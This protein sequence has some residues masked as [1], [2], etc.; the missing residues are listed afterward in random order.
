MMALL[1]NLAT[2]SL[3]LPTLTVPFARPAAATSLRDALVAS[4]T[5]GAVADPVEV[6][7]LIAELAA[8][9]VPFRA[10]CLGDTA[11]PS[12]I[13][14]ACYSSGRTPRWERNAKLLSGFVQNRAGQAY[15]AKSQRVCNYGEVLGPSVYFTAE[16]SYSAVDSSRRCPK[17]FNVR[18]E[19][20]GFVLLGKPFVSG[21]ISGPGYLRVLY[22]D[23][24]VRIFESPTDSPDKWEEAGLR[25]VQVNERNF[26]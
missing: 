8:A 9:R 19:Q 11:D 16:G 18:I 6:D 25:V 2:P 20:G 7:A 13:W 12:A 14:R 24:D 26:A 1:L 10:K 23:D 4:E 15:D 3:N 21:A 17:D 22:L 5:G